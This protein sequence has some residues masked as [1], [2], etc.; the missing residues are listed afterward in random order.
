[1][2]SASVSFCGNTSSFK[3]SRKAGCASHR[4]RF[5][6]SLQKKE[7]PS[8]KGQSTEPSAAPSAMP[9]DEGEW[10]PHAGACASA[11]VRLRVAFVVVLACPACASHAARASC[12]ASVLGAGACAGLLVPRHVRVLARRVAAHTRLR[13]FNR[14]ATKLIKRWKKNLFHS[15]ALG[16]K[17]LGNTSPRSSMV[18]HS[19]PPCN[20]SRGTAT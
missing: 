18:N 2:S 12:R 8:S 19:E 11:S 4:W 13:V 15:G 20:T 17:G 14:S 3:N 10:L 5:K 7:S 1:M 9:I 16:R 6:S